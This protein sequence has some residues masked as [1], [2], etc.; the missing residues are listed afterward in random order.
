[1]KPLKQ[2]IL[3]SIQ[4]YILVPAASCIQPRQTKATVGSLGAMNTI[5]GKCDCAV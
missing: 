4:A 1:M 5:T 3:T 2:I